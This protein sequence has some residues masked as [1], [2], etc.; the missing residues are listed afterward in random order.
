MDCEYHKCQTADI[1]GTVKMKGSFGL[2][3]ITGTYCFPPP[4][5]EGYQAA[6]SEKKIS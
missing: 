2:L 4:K 5:N 3:G 6:G 1:L